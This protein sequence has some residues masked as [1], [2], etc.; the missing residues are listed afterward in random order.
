MALT[1]F[2]SRSDLGWGATPAPRTVTNLGIIAHYDAGYWLRN[3]R[4]ELKADGKSEHTAC[5]EYWQRVR[6]MHKGQGWVDVGY[7]YFACPDDYI[8]AGREVNHQQAA[9]LPTPGKIQNG[10]SRYVSCTFGLGPGEKPTAGALR[11]W[12]RLRTWL[13]SSHGLR[14]N[15]YGH[16]D[17]TSTDCPGDEIYRMVRDGTLK[18]SKPDPKPVPPTTP[19]TPPKDDEMIQYASFGASD[20]GKTELQPNTWTDVLF[21][22]EYADPTKVH[23][24]TGANPS[25]LKGAPT[26]YWFEFGA[27]VEGAVPG[28]VFDVDAAEYLYDGSANPPADLLKETGKPTSVMMTDNNS[29]HHTAVGS[30]SKDRKLRVRVRSHA[31]VPVKLSNARVSVAFSV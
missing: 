20:V 23:P 6:S 2:I 22:T 12:H 14:E 13:I 18:A 16:R 28:D 30:L 11:A 29:V 8:F 3:R 9:E 26:V 27:D 24:D 10:N 17:F 21:D 15:V 1:R 4:R 31:E 7:A 19:P 25:I 5:R